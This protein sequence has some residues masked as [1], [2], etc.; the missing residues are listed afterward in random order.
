MSIHLN[1]LE[2][3]I[4]LAQNGDRWEFMRDL[5]SISIKLLER[6]DQS[7]KE[8]IAMFKLGPQTELRRCK[9]G[10]VISFRH[11]YFKE[12]IVLTYFSDPPFPEPGTIHHDIQNFLKDYENVTLV[13]ADGKEFLISKV[14]FMARSEVFKAKLDR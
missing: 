7:E 1:L 4:Y 14:L 12:T 11:N 9:L 10:D 8:I 3:N 2:S 13:S 6:G 5:Y